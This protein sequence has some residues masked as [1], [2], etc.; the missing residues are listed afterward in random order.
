MRQRAGQRRHPRQVRDADAGG[1]RVDLGRADLDVDAR[2]FLRRKDDKWI[3]TLRRI[4]GQ[5]S[6]SDQ[7]ENECNS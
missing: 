1:V 2:R 3:R 4:G 7:P 6:A 5:Y